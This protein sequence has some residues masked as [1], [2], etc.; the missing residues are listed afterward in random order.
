MITK[1]AKCV[2]IHFYVYLNKPKHVKYVNLKK[3]AF[4]PLFQ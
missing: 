3:T 4:Q 2:F 1:D